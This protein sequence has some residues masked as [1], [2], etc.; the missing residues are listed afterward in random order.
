MKCVSRKLASSCCTASNDERLASRTFL[1]CRCKYLSK[2]VGLWVSSCAVWHYSEPEVRVH[3]RRITQGG[4]AAPEVQGSPPL[5]ATVCF[6]CSIHRSR[7]MLRP[8]IH[9]SYL[10]PNV[11]TACI[12]LRQDGF[13]WVPSGTS[14]GHILS[15][16]QARHSSRQAAPH[17]HTAQQLHTQE[18]RGDLCSL[19]KCVAGGVS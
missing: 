6:T 2:P 7:G 16:G 9:S 4:H 12:Q 8:C 14:S 17:M 13:G 18:R 10:T 3:L 5:P 1:L 19:R 15:D 11:D